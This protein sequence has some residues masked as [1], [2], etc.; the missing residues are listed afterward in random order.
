MTDAPRRPVPHPTPETQP[1]WD[2]CKRHEL[3]I[4]YCLSCKEH[5]FYP[6]RFCP[7]CFGWDIEWRTVSGRGKLYTYSI[8]YRPQAPGFQPPYVTAIVQLDEG[9]RLMTNL[10]GVEPDPEKIRCDMPVEVDFLE[11]TDEIS[12]PVFKPAGS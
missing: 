11:L 4:P 2:A 9:P 6:R 5:F 10:V 1:Y 3:S 12:L 7:R 8:Q